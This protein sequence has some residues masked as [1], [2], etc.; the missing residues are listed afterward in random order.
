ML[1][2]EHWAAK[3]AGRVMANAIVGSVIVALIGA[4]CVGAAGALMG[5]LLDIRSTPPSWDS[6]FLFPGAWL[7]AYLGSYSGLVG[8]VA[9]GVAAFDFKVPLR[10]LLSRIALGQLLGTLGAVSSYLLLAL[11][12]AWTQSQPFTGTVEDNLELIIWGAPAAMIGGAIAGALWKRA[13]AT[14]MMVAK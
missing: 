6:G 14:V 9:A 8:A 12:I 11:A 13:D 7:G 2:N 1:I 3:I 10:A 4:L 5:W